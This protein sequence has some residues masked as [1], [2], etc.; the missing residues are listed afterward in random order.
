MLKG[1]SEVDISDVYTAAR[2]EIV[3]NHVLMHWF[4]LAVAVLLL[5]GVLIAES[6]QTILS[7][8]LP[9]LSLAWAAAMVRFDFFIHRQAA[10]LRAVEAQLQ[11]GGVSV[12]LWESW[13]MSLRSTQYIVPIAD[14]IACAVIVVPTIYLLFGPAQKFFQLRQWR[15]GNVYAW[16][17]SILILLLLCSLTVIPKIAAWGHGS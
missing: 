5:L 10:Y 15:W 6:R 2:A 14:V 16:S 3:S 9:L 11:A 7:V 17:I 4:T 1:V 8:F 13:K 12:P